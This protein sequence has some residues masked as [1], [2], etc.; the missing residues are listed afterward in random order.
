MLEE[1]E[2]IHSNLEAMI[3]KLQCLASVYS[4]EKMSQQVVDLGRESDEL[5]QMIKSRLQSLQ[6]AAKVKAIIIIA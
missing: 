2:E 3:K 4:T 1:S 5:R 6:D